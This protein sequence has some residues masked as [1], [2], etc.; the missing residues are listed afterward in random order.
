MV[1]ALVGEVGE[2]DRLRSACHDL[3]LIL[4]VFVLEDYRIV[5]G[6]AIRGFDLSVDV[7]VSIDSHGSIAYIDGLLTGCGAVTVAGQGE[8]GIFNLQLGRFTAHMLQL[9]SALVFIGITNTFSGCAVRH[10]DVGTIR[11][12]HLAGVNA[13]PLRAIYRDVGLI[14]GQ[15]LYTEAMGTAVLNVYGRSFL[16]GPLTA[17][18]E[19]AA[20]ASSGDG[21]ILHGQLTQSS[22]IRACFK[23]QR[24]EHVSK[25]HSGIFQ[26]QFCTISDVDAVALFLT[27]LG[28]LRSG[29][30]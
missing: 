2:R 10:G 26:T 9:H 4:A 27:I 20:R 13:Y 18:G 1:V 25:G 22:C 6:S 11:K 3:R 21:G 15:L 12:G 8:G 19:V 28:I 7:R 23:D 14:D 5:L 24:R 17:I 30:V 16:D 29:N